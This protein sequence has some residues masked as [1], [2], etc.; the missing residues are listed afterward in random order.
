MPQLDGNYP[1][2]FPGNLFHGVIGHI[3]HHR[4]LPDCS[5]LLAD[6]PSLT[7]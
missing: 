3:C 2:Q 6:Q 1:F 7:Q 5:F 4:W